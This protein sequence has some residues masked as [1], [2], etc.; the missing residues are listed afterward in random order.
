MIWKAPL[1]AALLFARAA[2]PAAP[3]GDVRLPVIMYHS[4]SESPAGEFCVSPGDF[5]RDLI[6]L[7]DNGYTAVFAS[8]AAAYVSGAPGARMPA[9]P[10]MLTFD[11]GYYNN[12]VYALPL[13]KQY[14][15]KAVLSVI[16]RDSDIW[17]AIPSKSLRDGHAT[18]EEIAE[19]H[20]SGHIEIANH[21]YGLH[22]H[23]RRRGCMRVSGE[24]ERAYQ[25][26]LKED[27]GRLQDK[28]YQTTGVRPVCF[29]YPYGRVSPEAARPLSELGLSVTLG[30]GEKVNVIARA[31][32]ECLLNMGRYNRSAA[33]SAK[34]ILELPGR[35]AAP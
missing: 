11:D 35:A 13:L 4:I 23:G 8:E 9:R 19:M 30:V 6:Y 29:A 2:V 1:M 10:V 28:L 25:S 20:A 15:M 7:R 24:N 3:D 16:G 31:D 21:T 14:G 27:V 22:S 26:L 33:R 34:R 12:Y 32:P 5:E 18:W 17:S